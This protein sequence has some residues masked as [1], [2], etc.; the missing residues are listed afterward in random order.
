MSLHRLDPSQTLSPAGSPPGRNPEALSSGRTLPLG[1]GHPCWR[2]GES[3]CRTP[4]LHPQTEASTGGGVQGDQVRNLCP[5]VEDTRT[6]RC[7]WFSSAP[8]LLAWVRAWPA[9]VPCACVAGGARGPWTP[10][11][12]Q[13]VASPR[14]FPGSF[15]PGRV[16]EHRPRW[17]RAGSECPWGTDIPPARPPAGRVPGPPHGTH[18]RR[19]HPRTHE[20]PLFS[21]RG[22]A[23]DSG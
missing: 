11:G 1:P 3:T 16:A 13:G 10:E 14:L 9:A 17:S 19:Q 4:E 2:A 6:G 5:F 20:A 21:Q 15:V 22:P 12:W 23:G 8:R 7:A 18:E